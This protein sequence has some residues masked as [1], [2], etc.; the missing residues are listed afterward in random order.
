[1]RWV[2]HVTNLGEKENAYRVLVRKPD[3]K[4]CLEDLGIAVR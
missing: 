4:H 3:G 2:G 1:M